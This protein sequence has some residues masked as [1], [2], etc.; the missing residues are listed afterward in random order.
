MSWGDEVEEEILKYID[1]RRQHREENDEE[2]F[3]KHVAIVLQRLPHRER[4]MARLRFEQVL[5]DAK[6]PEPSGYNNS[7][8]FENI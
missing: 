1:A 3:G 7:Y 4:V 6:F 5:I 8:T 2:L